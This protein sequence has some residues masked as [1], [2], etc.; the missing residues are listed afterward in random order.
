MY[1]NNFIEETADLAAEH[2]F[3]SSF[4]CNKVGGQNAFCMFL[5]CVPNTW[6][7]SRKADKNNTENRNETW[8]V[9]IDNSGHPLC[10]IKLENKK[11][12]EKWKQKRTGKN[13]AHLMKK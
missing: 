5:L 12:N 4:A 2:K 3:T 9:D 8:V 10:V 6:P 11:L 7:H 1:S 13:S